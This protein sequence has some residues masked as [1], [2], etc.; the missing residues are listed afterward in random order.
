MPWFPR[1]I[2]DLDQTQRVL[3]Y[4]SDLDADHPVSYWHYFICVACAFISAYG[5]SENICALNKQG[6]KDPV[7]RRRRKYFYDLAM[8]YR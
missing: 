5:N 8:E 1:R 6:F 4:G 3:V 7:Y 2:S